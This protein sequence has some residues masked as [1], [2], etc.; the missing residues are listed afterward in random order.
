LAV[1]ARPAAGEHRL[2][3][4]DEKNCSESVQKDAIYYICTLFFFG[5]MLPLKWYFADPKSC[6][7]YSYRLE[8]RVGRG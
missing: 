7:H 1:R 6:Y 2:R 4:G 8:S 5:S 3:G